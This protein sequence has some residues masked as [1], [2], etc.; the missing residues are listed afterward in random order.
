MHPEPSEQPSQP[1][2]TSVHV[3][4]MFPLYDLLGPVHVFGKIS[5][6]GGVGGLISIAKAGGLV[7]FDY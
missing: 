1:A 4:R 2:Y 3:L 6:F 7:L 5:V